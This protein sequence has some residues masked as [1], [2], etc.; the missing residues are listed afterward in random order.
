MK[1]FEFLRCFAQWPLLDS[2]RAQAHS[3]DYVIWDVCWWRW[4][5]CLRCLHVRIKRGFGTGFVQLE[6]DSTPIANSIA[7]KKIN[8]FGGRIVAEM[9]NWNQTKTMCYIIISKN[10][11]I[12][13]DCD[14]TDSNRRNLVVKLAISSCFCN[15]NTTKSICNTGV[16]SW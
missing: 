9:T 14:S 7:F 4:G 2:S 6:T 13:P 10:G 12:F 3:R 1:R 15:H 16:N 5:V 8:D 11:C